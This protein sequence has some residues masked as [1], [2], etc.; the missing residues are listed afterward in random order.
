MTV[1][2]L[3]KE[4]QE[5]TTGFLYSHIPLYCGLD[6]RVKPAVYDVVMRFFKEE[7]QYQRI[8]QREL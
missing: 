4:R 1:K 2:E 7:G 5:D 8:R 6:T 3:P